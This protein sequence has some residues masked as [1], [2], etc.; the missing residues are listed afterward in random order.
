MISHLLVLTLAF[1]VGAEARSDPMPMPIMEPVNCTCECSPGPPAQPIPTS[2]HVL[3]DGHECYQDYYGAIKKWTINFAKRILRD[4]DLTYGK[5]FTMS[6]ATYTAESLIITN[7]IVHARDI[8]WSLKESVSV[9]SLVRL[10]R[11]RLF[12]KKT[13]PTSAAFQDMSGSAFLGGVPRVESR[14]HV[15]VDITNAKFG[16]KNETYY[17]D[18]LRNLGSCIEEIDMVVIPVSISP[19]CHPDGGYHDKR[20]PDIAELQR[21]SRIGREDTSPI[22]EMKNSMDVMSILHATKN[23][24][25][26]EE[27]QCDKCFCDC[28]AEQGPKGEKGEFVVGEKGSEGA[29]DESERDGDQG[30]KGSRGE[31]GTTGFRG[32]YGQVGKLGAPGIAGEE[33]K[34][35]ARGF[36]GI[37]GTP[38]PRGVPGSE[39]GKGMEG[40]RG[41][42]GLRGIFGEQGKK[43]ES[44]LGVDGYTGSKGYRGVAGDPGNMGNHGGNGGKGRVGMC[45]ST[46]PMG[47]YGI[48]GPAG[49]QGE[50]GGD[51]SVG[52]TGPPGDHGRDGKKGDAGHEGIEGDMGHRGFQGALGDNGSLGPQGIV[53]ECGTLSTVP[54]PIGRRGPIGKPAPRGHYGKNGIPGPIGPRGHIGPLGLPGS[55]GRCIGID[56][57]EFNIE[58]SK[59]M[60]TI[61]R[62]DCD[63]PILI[64]GR[65]VR[66]E[67]PF[68]ASSIASTLTI[69]S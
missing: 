16:N 30:D 59:Y 45:G 11:E 7:G 27:S 63:L 26:P 9:K 29:D 1:L 39:G 44:I 54:G 42:P 32:E 43:G 60:R 62:A 23:L 47:A 3:I 55:E 67:I 37:P 64:D 50:K 5:N 21:V 19:R 18:Y 58:I 38:G 4:P 33:G 51:G 17:Q 10:I 53:G 24:I 56:E 25:L 20:C 65:P 6:I 52:L 69:Q 34:K 31:K 15:I 68:A 61:I 66:G 35:G 49:I 13:E 57:I 48:Q 8:D 12:T 40:L 46:G 41:L 22:Y 36:R 14:K 28:K 2:F